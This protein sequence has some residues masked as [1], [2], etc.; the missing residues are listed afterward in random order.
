MLPWQVVGE[1][2]S[3]LRRWQSRKWIDESRVKKNAAWIRRLFPIELPTVAV[4]DRALELTTTA[5]LSHWDAMLVAACLE[6]G[7]DTLYSEDMGA[8]RKIES[9]TLVN[10][11]APAGT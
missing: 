7:I 5:T 10:P 1:F 8:P 11:F 9:L 3:Q 6:A 4:I 2:L